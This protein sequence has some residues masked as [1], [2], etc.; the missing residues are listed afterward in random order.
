M[1][2]TNWRHIQL[3]LEGRCTYCSGELPNHKGV[4]PVYGEELHKKW[5]GINE[6]LEALVERIDKVIKNV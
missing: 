6:G 1:S 3:K 5:Q 4:C 2:E